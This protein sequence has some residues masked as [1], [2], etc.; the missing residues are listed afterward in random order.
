M[1]STI[2]PLNPTMNGKCVPRSKEIMPAS[3]A[4]PSSPPWALQ[5]NFLILMKYACRH[6]PSEPFTI[7]FVSPSSPLIGLHV[8]A[9]ILIG[10]PALRSISRMIRLDEALDALPLPPR[11]DDGDGRE[12]GPARQ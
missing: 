4:H 2:L 8:N 9:S 7:K 1:A 3:E 11:Y 5:V 12:A 6:L 10:T